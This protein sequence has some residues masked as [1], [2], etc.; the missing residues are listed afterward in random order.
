MKLRSDFDIQLESDLLNFSVIFLY[1][2]SKAFTQD[3][4]ED[5]I[6]QPYYSDG[7][8]E[9]HSIIWGNANRLE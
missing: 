8:M 6:V 4:P 5:Y 3:N 9:I 2:K 1:Y 7:E